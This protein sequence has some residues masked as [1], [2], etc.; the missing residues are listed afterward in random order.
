MFDFEKL[1]VYNLLRSLNKD[2]L[3]F[4]LASHEIDPFLKDQWK[5]AT[6]GAAINLAEGVGRISD[7]DKKHYF[8]ISRGSIFES[9]SLMHVV[10]DLDQMTQAEFST[11]YDQ[12]ETV[13]KMLLG[14]YRSK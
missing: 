2:V 1:D 6:I 12:Y 3:K 10:L 8:T 14:L 7:A 11:F 9:V 5:R 4:L 13:S